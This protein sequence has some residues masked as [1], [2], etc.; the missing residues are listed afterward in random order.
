MRSI[1][2]GIQTHGQCLFLDSGVRAG[3]NPGMTMRSHAAQGDTLMT[4]LIRLFRAAAALAVAGILGTAPALAQQLP[5]GDIHLIC[6]FQAGSGADA[7]VHGGS[8]LASN[9]QPSRA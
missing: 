5:S 9:M 4:R 6:G 8:G 3:A 7:I 1:E 2:P